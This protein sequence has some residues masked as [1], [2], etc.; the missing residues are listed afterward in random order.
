MKKL[1]L[2]I[3][4]ALN[5]PFFTP[6]K[7]HSQS[8]PNLNFSM[9]NF[10]GWQ[11]YGDMDGFAIMNAQQLIQNNDMYDEYC[12]VIPKVP[13]GFMYSAKIG[14][15][16]AG[17]KTS[18]LEYTLRVDSSNSL[19]ILHFAY[20]MQKSD[21]PL[22]QQP[23]FTMQIRD[24]LGK[25]FV[26]VPC[27]NI[28][29][30]AQSGMSGLACDMPNGF[31]AKNWT[32]VG[33]SLEALMGRTINIYFET[34]NCAL[35]DHFGYAYIVAECK[36][37]KIELEF[38]VGQTD[39]RMKAPDGFVWYKWT[40]SLQ[41]HWSFEGTEAQAK[42]IV[43]T[44]PMEGEV[45]TC[46]LW[47]EFGAQCS[48][49]SKIEIKRTTIDAD[50]R[51]GY[52]SSWEWPFNSQNW[53]DT[54][55]R[56]AIFIDFAT[57]TNS[58]KAGILWEIF[59]NKGGVTATSTDSLFTYTFPDPDST[60][61]T[62]RVRLTCFAEN[63][64]VDTSQNRP[65]QHITIYSSSKIKIDGTVDQ[66]CEDDTAKLKAITI[67]S[68]FVEYRWNWTDKDGITQTATGDSLE[69]YSPGTYI[70]VARDTAGCYAID[71]FKVTPLKALFNN[72][73]T[74][75]ATCYGEATGSFTHDTIRGGK[76]PY[77]TLFW[78]FK[79]N[80]GSDTIVEAN[81]YFGLYTNLKAGIYSL[82]AI[83][84]KGCSV[85][86]EVEIK[87]NDSLRLALT[88]QSATCDLDNGI[89]HLTATGGVPPYQYTIENKD[90]T[91][92]SA[93]SSNTVS[94]LPAD[95][96]I[97]TVSD[98]V[99]CETSDTITLTM[100]QKMYTIQ[101]EVHCN[102]SPLGGVNIRYLHDT[103]Y[104][105]ATTNTLG[106]YG[107][108]VPCKSDVTLIPSLSGYNFTPEYI[109]LSNVMNDVFNQNFTATNVGI[110]NYELRVAN[111]VVYPNPTAGKFSVISFKLSEMGGAVEIYNV[112]GQVVGTYRIRPEN[113]KTEIDISHLPA[114][115]Y[116]LK[117]D[118]KMM[119]VVK[120]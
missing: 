96:Y 117:T 110:S 80:G 38:C 41:P 71:T 4:L 74:T 50:F 109:A 101:G 6:T 18:A 113:T 31:A 87:Q 5:V 21:H 68:K 91:F 115:L 12:P 120:Q 43:V 61:V 79:D 9:G 46:E 100:T 32:T 28:I 10:T 29:F 52:I 8:C 44:N 47:S 30:N 14:N 1:F 114:G 56:T 7:L 104:I 17:V 75:N 107:I 90:K 67:R 116:F 72:L 33:F 27:N 11:G 63:G 45:F 73:I 92:M 49:S 70:I 2:L 34:K 77:D 40:G 81:P 3:G 15:N 105:N 57:V 20:V 60:P 62:Y 59:D 23:Q 13:N 86:G 37:M 25:A 89:L 84:N 51:Y 66:L 55:A 78:I 22:G 64:C 118:G 111:Y 82:N 85:Y 98:F 35:G 69:I 58:K 108:F 39:A 106:E 24:S 119:K 93:T 54:C 26:G 112:V 42:Q 53:Y 16:S 97:I 36:P 95:T 19:L 94:N 76:L 103:I 83:D 48:E 99:S 65:D 102:G 88:Q